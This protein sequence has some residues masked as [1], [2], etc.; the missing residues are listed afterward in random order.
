VLDTGAIDHDAHS[1]LVADEIDHTSGDLAGG[2]A[3]AA[4]EGQTCAFGGRS[5]L[6]AA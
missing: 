3:L 5:W 6:S 4:T 1:G 2:R